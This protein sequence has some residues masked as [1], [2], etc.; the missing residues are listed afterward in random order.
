MQFKELAWKDITSDGVIVCSHCDINLCGIIKIEF[1]INHEPKENK[2]YLYTFGKGSLRRLEP[3]KYD[4]V[5]L[6]K[7]KAYRTYSNEMARIKKAVDFL[8]A[9]DIYSSSAAD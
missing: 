7:N 1:R 8:V 3:E 6:A 5:E 9:D 4:F 2:Y